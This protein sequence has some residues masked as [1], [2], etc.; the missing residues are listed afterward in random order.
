MSHF[1][2]AVITAKKEK[3]EEMLAS[4]DENL[5]VEPY[6]ERTK[7]EI[8]KYMVNHIKKY[9][10]IP[11]NFLSSIKKREKLGITE[12]GNKIAMP[13]PDKTLTEESF[14]C[15][16]I[17]ENP[18]IWEKKEVQVVF[19][20]SVSKKTDKK[21]KYFYKV[22]AKFLLNKKNIEKLIK[23]RK[24]EDLILMLKNIEEKMEDETNE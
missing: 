16:G 7:E 5:E 14:V 3:L 15:V 13:H 10:I 11:N 18:I 9:K 21:L 8:L 24:Y 1:T 4:Y 2:V 22:T 23:S 17:L 19:L 12:F 6:I 20:V